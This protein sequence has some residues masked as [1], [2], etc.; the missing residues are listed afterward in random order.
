MNSHHRRKILIFVY[1]IQF[2]CD[3]LLS[4]GVGCNS[5]FCRGFCGKFKLLSAFCAFRFIII[6][7]RLSHGCTN[8]YTLRSK[9]NLQCCSSGAFQFAV[10]A[11]E[12]TLLGLEPLQ[13][14]QAS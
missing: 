3:D 10:V 8:I 1:F 2:F 9:G 5:I 12:R 4:E 14:G 11:E 7:I 6:F 13:V